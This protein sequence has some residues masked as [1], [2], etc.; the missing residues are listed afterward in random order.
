MTLTDER[1]ILDSKIKANQA[2][3]D[4]DREAATISAL[5]SS[6]LKKYEYLTGEDLW[7]E[8]GV[9]EKIKFEY[10]PLGKV[11]D[12]RLDE[13]DKKEGILKGSKNIESKNEEQLKA[14]EDQE[15]RQLYVIK[16]QNKN[17]LKTIKMGD[18]TKHVV[19]LRKE[20][21]KLFKMYSESFEKRSRNLL[22][23]F[24]R[25]ES[26]DYNN[27]SYKICFYGVNK[28]KFHI[29]DFL[30]DFDTL[31]DLLKDLVTSKIN[32]NYVK[33]IVKNSKEKPFRSMKT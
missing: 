17:Q 2:Q 19:Y 28:N 10:F 29:I 24:T 30:K 33:I 23:V 32:T 20:I 8:R 3:Y 27:L 9:L 25:N 18:K 7:Y 14:I 31:H 1:K 21:D 26:V 11:F 6:E 4:L 12:K 22:N 13:S 5:S 16:K 15:E